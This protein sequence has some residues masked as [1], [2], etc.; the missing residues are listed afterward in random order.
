[1]NT[2]ETSGAAETIRNGWRGLW[3]SGALAW[4]LASLGLSGTALYVCSLHSWLLWKVLATPGNATAPLVSEAAHEQLTGLLRALENQE[5][6]FGALALAFALWA[7]RHPPRWPAY[8]ALFASLFALVSAC[9][10]QV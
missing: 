4:G 3:K 2:H 10:I 9:H 1:M 8:I 6:V 5:R 7:L